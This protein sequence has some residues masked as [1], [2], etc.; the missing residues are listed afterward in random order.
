MP[1]PP[2]KIKNA[3]FYGKVLVRRKMEAVKKE[4][5]RKWHRNNVEV[6]IMVCLGAIFVFVFG[7]MPMFGIIL[8][9][10]EGDNALN[11]MDAILH[12]DW[13]EMG[14]FK[15][16]YDFL[17]DPY[18]FEIIVNT[19]G[20][21]LLN[22]AIS[23]PA[24]VII[25]LLFNELK[26]VKLR[27]GIQFFTFLPHFVSIVVWVGIIHSLCD[28]QTG[29]VN[30]IL[31]NMGVIKQSIDFK[32]DPQYSW[33]LMISS[34]VL[35]GAGWGSIVYMA[36]IAGV[37]E[38]LY[39][40][41]AIDGVNRLQKAWYITLPVVAPLFVLNLILN[42][43]NILENGAATMLLWQTPSNL[44]KTEVFSTFI[45]KNGINEMLYSYA[46]AAGFFQSIVGII[47]LVLGNWLAKKI[48]GKGVIF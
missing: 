23:M 47:L 7:Y 3:L 25:A 4:P 6:F 41:A 39:D 48:T 18:F 20:F 32:G 9:F 5:K 24:P 40:A 38:E 45:L 8:A 36:A 13:A 35:K 16:F 1:L 27:K 44:E 29:V 30:V 2:A 42:L 14:G 37:D 34:G 33:G 15:N 17:T 46:T 31:K 26:S 12:S 28:T 43:S 19:L 21:N 10:K 11:I 22:L